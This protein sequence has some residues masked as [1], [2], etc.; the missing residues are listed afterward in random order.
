M[1]TAMPSNPVETQYEF[2]NQSKFSGIE[3]HHAGATSKKVIKRAG[4][5]AFF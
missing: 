2:G 1:T 3:V 4:R 5:W